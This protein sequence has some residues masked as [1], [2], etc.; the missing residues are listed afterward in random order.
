MSQADRNA[1]VEDHLDLVRGILAEVAVRYP[2]H[3]DREE[4]WSA[5]ALGLVEASRRYDPTTG[6]PF[7]RYAAIR[8][9]GAIV[10]STRTRDWATR[11]VRR[12]L[13]ETGEVAAGFEEDHGRPPTQKEL[14]HALGISV[15]QLAELRAHASTSLLL[16]LDHR[17]DNEVPLREQLREERTEVLPDA[18]LEQ[19]ELLGTLQSALEQLCPVQREVVARYYLQ[20]ELL[21]DIAVGFG[22]TEARISQLRREALTALRSYFATLYEGVAPVDRDAP[23]GRER[24]LYLTRLGAGTTWRSRLDAGATARHRPMERIRHLDEAAEKGRPLPVAAAG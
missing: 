13:R 4:L 1:L 15:G 8:I 6:V 16:H 18:A 22:V 9:R 20:G 12:R 5:G 11:T 24:A 23:G 17:V 21:Q 10:D 2:R 14:A 3:V 19:C 7:A